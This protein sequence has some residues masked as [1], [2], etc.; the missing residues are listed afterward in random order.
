MATRRCAW[1]A[2]EISRRS[3]L[4]AEGAVARGNSA[5]MPAAA[6]AA[7]GSRQPGPPLELNRLDRAWQPRPLIGP[8]TKPAEYAGRASS[9]TAE[10]SREA[11][12]RLARSRDLSARPSRSHLGLQMHNRYLV[13][14]SDDG[15]VVIDQHALH[16]RILY[17]QL[18][19]KVLAGQLESQRLL[20]PEPVTCRRRQGRSAGGSRDTGATWH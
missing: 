18:R 13:T 19:E 8:R 16:E 14:E 12:F 2:M 6:R 1:G 10:R 20:V 7:V 15:M 3:D 17:E 4:A 9:P 5:A 11:R